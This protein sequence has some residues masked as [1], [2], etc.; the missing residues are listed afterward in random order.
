MLSQ[1]VPRQAVGEAVLG[2]INQHREIAQ[3]FGGAIAGLADRGMLP[4]QSSAF[5]AFAKSKAVELMTGS[6]IGDA[7]RAYKTVIDSFRLGDAMHKYNEVGRFLSESGAL[8]RLA[9]LPG[10]F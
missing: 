3:S 9:K 5:D 10:G 1:L 7:M 8:G 6:V 4:A 2:I